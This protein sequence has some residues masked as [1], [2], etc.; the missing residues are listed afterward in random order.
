MEDNASLL[1]PGQFIKYNGTYYLIIDLEHNAYYA[2]PLDNGPCLYIGYLAPIEKVEDYDLDCFLNNNW[3][4]IFPI[5]RE[6]IDKMVDDYVDSF[7]NVLHDSP[8]KSDLIGVMADSY[9]EGIEAACK[10]IELGL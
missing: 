3:D 7:S 4:K 1:K 6:V 5:S 9:R 8:R 10:R 2:K